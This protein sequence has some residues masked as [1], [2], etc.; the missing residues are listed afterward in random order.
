MKRNRFRRDGGRKI[1]AAGAIRAVHPTWRQPRRFI[2]RISTRGFTLTEILVSLIVIG[3][4]I[5]ALLASVASSTKINDSGRKLTTASFIAQEVR[6]WTIKLPFSDPDVADQGNPPGPDGY[7]PQVYVDD[8]D[9]LA[10]DDLAGVT[11]SPPRN[12]QGSPITDMTDWSQ[13]IELSWRDPD[14]LNTVVAAG[15]SDVIYVQVTISYKGTEVLK[16]GWLVARRD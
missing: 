12:G 9:D 14:N 10:G 5:V 11:Y 2:R 16:T 7:D 15:G 4:G 1:E 3:M 8:L 13:F 6:E